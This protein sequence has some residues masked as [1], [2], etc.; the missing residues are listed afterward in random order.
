M[1]K[2][3]DPD[4]AMGIIRGTT[5]TLKLTLKDP[6]HSEEDSEDPFRGDRLLL[7]GATIYFSVKKDTRDRSPLIQ[8][9]TAQSSEIAIIAAREGLAEIYLLPADTN[10][11][12]VGRYLYD[13]WVVMPDGKRHCAVP[14]SVFEVLS[15]VTNLL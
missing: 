4:N 11:L 8:K 13:I 3:L 15:S 2:F 6:D 5:N 14:P 7:T 10:R 12:D 9:T 1:S